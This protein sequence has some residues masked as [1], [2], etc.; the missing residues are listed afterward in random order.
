VDQP[1]RSFGAAPFTEDAMQLT[2]L[3]LLVSQCADLTTR[4]ERLQ[5]KNPGRVEAQPLFAISGLN[6]DLQRV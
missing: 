3:T 4:L 1:G 6:S 5:A 2:P